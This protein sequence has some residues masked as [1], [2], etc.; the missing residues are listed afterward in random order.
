MNKT[1]VSTCCGAEQTEL[2]LH[3]AMCMNHCDWEEVTLEE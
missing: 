2:Y 1:L 3:C